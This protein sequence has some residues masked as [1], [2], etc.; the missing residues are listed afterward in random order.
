[1]LPIHVTGSMAGVGAM[2]T[3]GA[4]M[5]VED[6]NAQ[7]GI[8][9][10]PVRLAIRDDEGNPTKT[11]T[12]MQELYE[13]GNGLFAVGPGMSAAGL[14]CLDY[15]TENKIINVFLTST[16]P[17]IDEEAWP[18]AFRIFYGS[19]IMARGMVEFA[20][21]NSSTKVAVVYDNS[22]TGQDGIASTDFWFEELN[23]D[24][25]NVVYIPFNMDEVDMSPVAQQIKDSGADVG[26][27]FAMGAD[28]ARIVQ[29]LERIDYGEGKIKVF[30]SSGM[31]MPNFVDLAG[32][33]AR[34]VYRLQPKKVTMDPATMDFDDEI[35]SAFHARVNETYGEYG[36]GRQADFNGLTASYVGTLTVLRAIEMTGSVDSDVLKAYL[37][38]GKLNEDMP[39][40]KLWLPECRW[41]AENHEAMVSEDMVPISMAPEKMNRDICV[42]DE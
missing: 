39:E 20:I 35:V 7:G 29:A 22:T 32:D 17:V 28:G 37:E 13:Q 23:V 11:L 40:L 27:F 2:H 24:T 15:M 36:E 3:E 12:Y 19:D 4:K 18:Y 26:L 14:A 31:G 25:S 30:G 10:V 38:S 6:Y 5:A 8:H 1:M 16:G 9:G 34:L 33:A 41:T 42:R 21:A